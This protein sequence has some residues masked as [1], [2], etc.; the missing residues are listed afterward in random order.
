MQMR[1]SHLDLMDIC[2]PQGELPLILH[3]FWI[4]YE[5]LILKSK[6]GRNRSPLW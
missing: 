6:Y 3:I 4:D 2:L 5:D 1:G